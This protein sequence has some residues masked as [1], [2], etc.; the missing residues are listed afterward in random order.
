MNRKYDSTA[1]PK[2]LS[3]RELEILTL[4]TMGIKSEN[5]AKILF[6][7]IATVKKT[8]G[9]IYLKL[10]AKNKTNAV[11]IAI[12][13]KMIDIDMI[14]HITVK[15]NLNMEDYNKQFMFDD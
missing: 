3:T 5:I 7:S 14:N 9:N 2:N 1:A 10:N 8:L 4:A 6:I 12:L 15:Y 11:A 13:Y